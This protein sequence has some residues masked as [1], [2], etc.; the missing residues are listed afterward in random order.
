MYCKIALCSIP[1]LYEAII[2]IKDN[3]YGFKEANEKYCF[4][5]DRENLQI[6]LKSGHHTIKN[7]VLKD[8][9]TL[10]LMVHYYYLTLDDKLQSIKYS[11]E[12]F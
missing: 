4:C 2:S 6:N 8:L 10:S 12:E 5:P 7:L 11:L 9:S 1:W 3:P